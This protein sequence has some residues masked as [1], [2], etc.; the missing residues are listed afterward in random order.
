VSYAPGL[1]LL[2]RARDHRAEGLSRHPWRAY[3]GSYQAF[4]L[5]LPGS[6]GRRLPRGI[7]AAVPR[8]YAA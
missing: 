1:V 6:S 2:L 7:S 3:D 4:E 5:M 8:S